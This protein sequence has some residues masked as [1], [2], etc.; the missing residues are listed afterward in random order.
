V[1]AFIGHLQD[2]TA[3][4]YGSSLSYTL[5]RSLQLRNTRSLFRFYWSLLRNGFQRRIFPFLWVPKLLTGFSYQLLTFQNCNSQLTQQ[6][7]VQVTSRPT[8]SRPVRLGVGPPLGNMTKT[9][10]KK[11]HGLSPRANYTD[12]ATAACRRSDCQLLRIKGATWSARRIP[13]AVFSVF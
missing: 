12:R 2:V 8:V 3:D 1:T 13:S 5:Q 9:K 4:N 7:Q 10:Q 6:L 11:N